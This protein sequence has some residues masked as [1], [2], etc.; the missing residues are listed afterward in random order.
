MKCHEAE[1]LIPAYLLGALDEHERAALETHM[2]GCP[3]CLAL[4]YEESPAAVT[5][6][7]MGDTLQAP[8]GLKQRILATVDSGAKPKTRPEMA[9]GIL[10]LLRSSLRQPMAASA[11]A[12]VAI[13]LVGLSLAALLL[14]MEVSELKDEDARLSASLREQLEQMQEENQ[15]ISQLLFDQLDLAYVAAMPGVSTVMLDGAEASPRSR[16]MLMISPRATWAVL[17]ALN[18]QPLPRDQAYQL[19][20]MA[21]GARESGGTFTVN[22]AGYGQLMVQGMG[23]IRDFENIGVSIEP[24]EGSPDPTGVNVLEGTITMTPAETSQAQDLP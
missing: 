14:W 18:L 16:G 24:A 13:S 4:F 17:E 21:N 7:R 2:Q 8:L 10:G 23:S 9:G 20:L 5:L 19:W 3:G 15:K 11:M 22:S 12:L 6:S 1:E